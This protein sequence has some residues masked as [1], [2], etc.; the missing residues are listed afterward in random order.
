MS[1]PRSRNGHEQVARL[2]SHGQANGE[3]AGKSLADLIHDAEALHTTV[4]EA[5]TSVAR[6]IAGLRRHRKR[7]RHLSDALKSLRQLKLSEVAER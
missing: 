1:E 5:R 6:L 3:G 2:E 4:T 7:S